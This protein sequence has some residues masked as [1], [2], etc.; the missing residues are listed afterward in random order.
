MNKQE[1]IEA[2]A[3]KTGETKKRAG[4]LVNDFLD[5]LVEGTVDGGVTF[6]G[7]LSTTVKDVP[8]N[9]V[10]VGNPARWIKNKSQL[11]Y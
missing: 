8:A 5:L 3:T 7:I 1:F 9:E 4:E 2:Y 10:F 6:T 11:P